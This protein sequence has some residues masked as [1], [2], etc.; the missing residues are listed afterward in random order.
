MKLLEQVAQSIVEQTSSLLGVSMSITDA[1]GW[2]IGCDRK[3]R[4]GTF[5]SVSAQVIEKG[6]EMVFTK[7]KVK[8]MENVLPGVAAPI[9]LN[10]QMIGVL[11]IVG[12]PEE[13]K[14]YVAFVRSHIELLLQ[15]NFRTESQLVQMKTTELFVQHLI[16]YEGWKEESKLEE[17]RQLLGVRF[18][19]PRACLL[20]HLP[21]LKDAFAQPASLA[22][23]SRNELHNF[24]L[25]LFQESREDLV[26]PINQ[27]QWLVIKETGPE[28]EGKLKQSAER[29]ADQL[30][31]FLKRQG[32]TGSVSISCGKSYAG[33]EGAFR[34]YQQAYKALKAGLE[35]EPGKCVYAFDS[36]AILPDLLLEGI[37][38]EI[39]EL[40]ADDICRIWHHP[41][42]E[43][44][45]ETFLAY[46][47]SSMNVSRAARNL[48]V[49]RNTLAYRLNK[50]SE[51]VRIDLQSFE[52]CLVLYI[53]LKKRD[54]GSFICGARGFP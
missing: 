20:I 3:E 14:K 38:L 54:Q 51:M 24:I 1:D 35:K 2:I 26:C 25:H 31:A 39:L 22:G 28:K 5:H 7:E 18:D 17:Y 4:I 36:W 13:V 47:E 48:Y 49:H 21:G 11:G 10:H 53:A 52:Q 29:A 42:A 32:I 45:I 12:E 8:T 30:T 46:C 27:S 43:V 23:F 33:L 40:F 50:I 15:E 44:L 9:W 41:E 6:K 34:S 37:N 16:H 19:E